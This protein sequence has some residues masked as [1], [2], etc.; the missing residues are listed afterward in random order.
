MAKIHSITT[1]VMTGKPYYY[2]KHKRKWVTQYILDCT[3][4]I[5]GYKMLLLH[6]IGLSPSNSSFSIAS[7][8][9]R[10]EQEARYKWT[11]QTFFHVLTS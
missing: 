6:I 10:N 7:C 8:F 3:Y 9:M 2:T 5:N 4:K 11:L 1:T